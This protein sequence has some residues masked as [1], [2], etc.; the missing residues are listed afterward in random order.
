MRPQTLELTR[1]PQKQP[2]A[3]RASRSSPVRLQAD[4]Q[5]NA[6]PIGC[7]RQRYVNFGIGS[8]LGTGLGLSSPHEAG[9][10]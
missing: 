7:C 10:G 3:P 5:S 8:D 2:S 6:S 9:A 1:S 4:T